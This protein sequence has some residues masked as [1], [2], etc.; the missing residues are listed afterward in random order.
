MATT[1]LAAETHHSISG[2]L[3]R[4]WRLLL[5]VSAL[6]VPV[7]FSE[8]AFRLRA[9]FL[10][11]R[12]NYAIISLIVLL[13]S[14]VFRPLSLIIFLLILAAW[15]YLYLSRDEPVTVFDFPIDD[16]LMLIVLGLVTVLDLFLS[17]IWWNVFVSLVISA[18]MLGLHAVIRAPEDVDDQES[19]YGALLSVVDSPRGEYSQV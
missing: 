17:H 13:L 12:V 9:N 14:L 19:P 7:S 15:F 6:S 16:R 18:V 2:V 1:N 5:D 3:L 8:A 10:Y 11:F 4:P